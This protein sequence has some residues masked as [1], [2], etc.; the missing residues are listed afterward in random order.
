MSRDE[1]D[2]WSELFEHVPLNPSPGVAQIFKLVRIAAENAGGATHIGQALV[3]VPNVKEAFRAALWR[4]AG[5]R[6]NYLR[7]RSL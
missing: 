7:Q 1:E 2:G 4:G 5:V 3:K 6:I